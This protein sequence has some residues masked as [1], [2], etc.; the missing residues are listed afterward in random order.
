MRRVAFAF[1]VGSLLLGGLALPAEARGW[2]HRRHGHHHGHFAGGFVAG[3]TTALAFNALYTPRIVYA[4]PVVH[5]PLYYRG[6]V[7]RDVWVPGQWEI[8]TQTQNG[9][10]TYYQLWVASHWQRQCY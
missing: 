3:A 4:R 6:P 9:F 1:L 2:H 8:R 7:C 5:E 10:T